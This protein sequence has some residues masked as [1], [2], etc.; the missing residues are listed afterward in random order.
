MVLPRKGCTPSLWPLHRLPTLYG[1]RATTRDGPEAVGG[2]VPESVPTRKSCVQ[3]AS[4]GSTCPSRKDAFAPCA[5]LPLRWLTRGSAFLHT[6]QARK[7]EDR[8]PRGET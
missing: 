6:L 2:R 1:R 3:S 5:R 7:S 4:V 8:R